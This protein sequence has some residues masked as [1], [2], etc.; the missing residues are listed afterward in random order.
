MSYLNQGGLHDVGGFEFANEVN[1]RKPGHVV[2]PKVGASVLLMVAGCVGGFLAFGVSLTFMNFALATAALLLYLGVSWF[3][4]PQ[5]NH[6]NL[7]WMGGLMD[8]P[9]QV[10]DDYNRFLLQLKFLFWPGRFVTQSFLE[11]A[12]LFHF[13]PEVT[14]EDMI[15][16]KAAELAKRTA[17]EEESY[18]GGVVELS[19]ANYL[20]QQLHEVS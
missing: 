15:E 8:A 18:D 2:F 20:N 10:S 17:D 14:Y 4:R 9:M 1:V 12:T 11:L 5:P 19:S 3:V 13:I 6:N 7:G 16:R